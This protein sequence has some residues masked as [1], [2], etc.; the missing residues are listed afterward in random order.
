MKIPNYEPDV[1]EGLQQRHA[2]MP[3]DIFRMLIC[4]PSGSGKTNILLHMLYVL[5]EYDKVFLFSKNLHQH[6]YQPLLEY[7]AENINPQVK[8]EVTEAVPV[9]REDKIVPLEEL[10]IGNRKIFGL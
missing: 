1:S 9:G 5:L 3:T 8:Y 7:F 6:K 4:G 2:S 10:P